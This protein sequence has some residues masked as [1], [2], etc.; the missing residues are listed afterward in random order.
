MGFSSKYLPCQSHLSFRT[1][2]N[3]RD[4]AKRSTKNF[5]ADQHFPVIYFY[6]LEPNKPPMTHA[7]TLKDWRKSGNK[8]MLKIRDSSEAKLGRNEVELKVT[9]N[10]NAWNLANDLCIYIHF[11]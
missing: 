3:V 1:L 11:S 5:I 4:Q 10:M 6:Y 2:L 9:R 8:I 7:I